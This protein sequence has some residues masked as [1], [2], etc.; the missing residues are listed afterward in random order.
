MKSMFAAIDIVL[1][2]TAIVVM[3]IATVR[4]WWFI[5]IVI[6]VYVTVNT[7]YFYIAISGS[8][9]GLCHP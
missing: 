9:R 4:R 6:A 3:P 1:V 2:T 5:L 7:G 8:Y